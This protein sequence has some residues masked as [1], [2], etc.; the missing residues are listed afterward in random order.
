METSASENVNVDEA[1]L[2]MITR[3]HEITSQ[4]ILETKG[5]EN[6]SATAAPNQNPLGGTEIVHLDEVTA[7]QKTSSCCSI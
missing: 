3:I 4:K 2:Q 6:I 7:T 1:F 5:N